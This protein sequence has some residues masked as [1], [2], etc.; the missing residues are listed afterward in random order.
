MGLIDL[1]YIH[2][3]EE[4]KL[5]NNALKQYFE[6]LLDNQIDVKFLKTF[7]KYKLVNKKKDNLKILIKR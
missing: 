4:Q 5:F 3:K 7:E 2:L 1:K 6:L